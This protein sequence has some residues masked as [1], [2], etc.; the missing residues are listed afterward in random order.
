MTIGV[1]RLHRAS[2]EQDYSVTCC[3]NSNRSKKPEVR[4]NGDWT[5]EVVMAL[6]CKAHPLILRLKNL[7]YVVT[8]LLTRKKL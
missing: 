8:R 7:F 1:H 5:P 4:V 6:G 3:S 2:R